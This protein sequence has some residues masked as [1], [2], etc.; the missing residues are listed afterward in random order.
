LTSSSN[1]ALK[2]ELSKNSSSSSSR[3]SSTSKVDMTSSSGGVKVKTT[4]TSKM[5]GGHY[6]RREAE[7]HTPW[8]VTLKPVRQI[9]IEEEEA[10]EV[11][12][13]TEGFGLRRLSGP[14]KVNIEAVKK[15]LKPPPTVKVVPVPEIR[16]E[17]QEVVEREVEKEEVKT[18]L[19][20]QPP[21]KQVAALPD[22]VKENGAWKSCSEAFATAAAPVFALKSQLYK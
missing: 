11:E 15:P 14:K 8:G 17:I 16:I 3:K 10:T 9:R 7:T 21:P 19:T 2:K 22:K 5:V 20:K 12:T 18:V 13:A 4:K 1:S 6:L